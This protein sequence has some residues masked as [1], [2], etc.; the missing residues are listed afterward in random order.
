MISND[1]EA[2]S[3]NGKLFHA[4]AVATGKARLP[5]VMYKCHICQ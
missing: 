5:S 2:L 4:L 3:V 1:V